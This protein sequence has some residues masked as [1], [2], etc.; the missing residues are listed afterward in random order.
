MSSQTLP[1]TWVGPAVNTMIG[2]ITVGFVIYVVAAV[3]CAFVATHGNYNNYYTTQ[4][5]D[6]AGLNINNN[7]PLQIGAPSAASLASSKSPHFY[8]LTGR[9]AVAQGLQPSTDVRIEL[10]MGSQGS[11]LE[12]PFKDVSFIQR[13]HVV[14]SASLSVYQEQLGSTAKSWSYSLWDFLGLKLQQLRAHQPGITDSSTWQ[15][16][17]SNGA[18]SFLQDYLAHIY[19][20]LTPQQYARYLGG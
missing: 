5:L 14:S 4:Y 7:Y 17:E 12:L 8:L 15:T 11:V 16:I 18:P 6:R 9:D 1:R 3:I 20:T 10:Q 19:L 2:V 13:P